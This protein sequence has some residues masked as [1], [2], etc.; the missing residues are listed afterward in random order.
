MPEKNVQAED[1]ASLR[2][3]WHH[4]AWTAPAVCGM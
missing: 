2:R 1:L 4:T 3:P